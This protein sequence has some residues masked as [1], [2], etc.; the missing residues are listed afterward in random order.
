MQD[1]KIKTEQFEGPLDLLLSLIEKR[2]LL[3]NEISLNQVTDD[4]IEHIKS[5]SEYSLKNR[6]DFIAVASTLILI[7]SRSL[8]P[9]LSLTDEEEQSV[10]DLEER[11]KIYKKIKELSS[12]VEKKFGKNSIYFAEESKIINPVFSPHE[13]IKTSILKDALYGLLARIPIPQKKKEVIIKKVISM[14][15]MI[16]NLTT[17]IQGALKMSFKK[18]SGAGEEKTEK[19]NVIVSFLALLELVKQGILDAKQDTHFDD[20]EMETVS[21]GVPRY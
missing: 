9:N 19:V 11:L 18:F 13:S 3:I 14:E 20:I 8:L 2:K 6:A 4:Y 5:I 10:Q 15:E 12:H 1:F 21:V 16:E 17:R 7:K